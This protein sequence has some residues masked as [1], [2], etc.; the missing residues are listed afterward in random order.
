[1]HYIYSLCFCPKQS[2]NEVQYKPQ[3]IKENKC[4]N[5]QFHVPS[6]TKAT[7]LQVQC[8]ETHMKELFLLKTNI[9]NNI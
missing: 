4:C 1:M 7:R 8:S 9:N 2:T 6:D 5:T 3:Y